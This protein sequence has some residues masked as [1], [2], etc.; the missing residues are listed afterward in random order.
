MEINIFS[1]QRLFV[2]KGFKFISFEYIMIQLRFSTS[3][4]ENNK[5]NSDTSEDEIE[6][7]LITQTLENI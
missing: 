4:E 5:Y 1:W 3:R 6:I 2:F 7:K